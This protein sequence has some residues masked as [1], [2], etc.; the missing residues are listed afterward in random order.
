MLLLVSARFLLEPAQSTLQHLLVV[1]HSCATH[2]L[3]LLGFLQPFLGWEGIDSASNPSF[4]LLKD[5]SFMRPLQRQHARSEILNH[6][7]GCC[8]L[9]SDRSFAE[10]CLAAIANL[11]AE[12]DVMDATEWAALGPQA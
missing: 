9:A 4:G 7:L 8:K 5:T 11:S 1:M 12:A 6:G 3:Q 2:S 10:D